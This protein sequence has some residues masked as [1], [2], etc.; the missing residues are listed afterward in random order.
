VPA[1]HYYILSAVTPAVSMLHVA[2]LLL[3][4]RY[5]LVHAHCLA[6]AHTL[7]CYSLCT[8]VCVCLCVCVCVQILKLR[9]IAAFA[10]LDDTGRRRAFREATAEVAHMVSTLLAALAVAARCCYAL[11]SLSMIIQPVFT[12]VYAYTACCKACL[13]CA[14]L[15]CHIIMSTQVSVQHY[16]GGGTSGVL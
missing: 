9:D 14:L 6:Q 11:T 2:A 5:T 12:S 10:A 7:I 4:T 15:A 16:C 13:L 1:L 3:T 8:C